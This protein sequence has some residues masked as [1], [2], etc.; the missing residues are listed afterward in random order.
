VCREDADRGI[1]FSASWSPGPFK[2]GEAVTIWSLHQISNYLYAIYW[3]FQDDGV[4]HPEVGVTGELQGLNK[5]H[6]HNVFWRFVFDLDGS[7]DDRARRFT[8]TNNPPFGVD[9]APLLLFESANQLYPLISPAHIARAWR[10]EDRYKKNAHSKPIGYELEPNAQGMFRGVPVVEQFARNDFW[11]SRYHRC[12]MYAS[13]NDN[14]MATQ[15]C[16][17]PQ[18]LLRQSVA[19]FVSSPTP[20]GINGRD[21]VLWY[22]V[23]SHHDPRDEDSRHIPMGRVGPL[24]VPHD[25]SDQNPLTP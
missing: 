15:G 8:H 21:V 6:V 7:A 16:K 1:A 12:E 23:H 25:F 14:Y 5:M 20:Q 10:V 3:T 4:V 24:L 13:K 9:T 2:R 11:V 22:V 18:L 17:K 19:Q